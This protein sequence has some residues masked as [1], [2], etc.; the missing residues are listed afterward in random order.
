MADAVVAE[1][2]AAGPVVIFSKSFC[3][4]CSQVKGLFSQIALTAQPGP[5]LSCT[6]IVAWQARHSAPLTGS[7][8]R[9]HLLTLAHPGCTR[10]VVVLELDIRTQVSRAYRLTVPTQNKHPQSAHKHTPPPP[11][12]AYRRCRHHCI[13][14][15]A[16]RKQ[17]LRS[18]P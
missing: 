11:A 9:S 4:F 8:R 18:N 2:I 16:A 14:E 7:T 15:P 3:P 17:T 13:T 10:C 5:L 1:T 12:A 6:Q